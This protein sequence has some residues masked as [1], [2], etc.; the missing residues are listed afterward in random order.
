MHVR[1]GKP[2]LVDVDEEAIAIAWETQSPPPGMAPSGA[3]DDEW[4][5]IEVAA[6][7]EPR[8]DRYW[9][10]F[11]QEDDLDWPEPFEEPLLDGE[12]LRFTAPEDKLQAAWEAVKRRVAAANDS[13]RGAPLRGWSETR[14]PASR[15][16]AELRER[17]QRRV[18]GLS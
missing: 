16:Y 14:C 4:V 3:E 6:E 13:L 2:A 8:P 15:L 11:W 5:E 17:A 9:L 12:T 7:L 10:V 1:L 18:D